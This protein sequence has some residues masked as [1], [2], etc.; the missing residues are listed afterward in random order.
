MKADYRPPLFHRFSF[1]S[2]V[3]PNLFRPAT[4][5]TWNEAL[6][7]T[8][9]DDF[10]TIGSWQQGA[11]TLVILLHGLEGSMHSRYMLGM[12]HALKTAG[13]DGIALNHRGCGLSSNRQAYSYHSGF[14]RDLRQLIELKA[15]SYQ[16]IWI[17]GFS[18]GGN[19]ALKYALDQPDIPSLTGVIAISAPIDLKG[20]AACLG[21]S[22]NK[23]YER[24]FLRTLKRKALLKC[25]D[26]PEVGLNEENIRTAKSLRAFDDAFTAPVNGFMN[27]DDY[28]KKC[29]TH[30]DIQKLAVPGLLI[31]AQNDSFLNSACY[32]PSSGKL[33]V[34]HPRF[35][36][37]VGF[38]LNHRMNRQFWHEVR[39]IEFIKTFTP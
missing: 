33:K 21:S 17:V 20:S 32:P 3:L 7:E 38:A 12:A 35:G 11:S 5:I 27:A 18:L 36:G 24:R 22:M 23:V 28:Y 34:L 13:Y 39:A 1:L 9:D 31:N 4:S 19:I 2:T 25:K 10:F 6:V 37:H 16:H 15:S 30:L 29:S 14:T 26:H 8:A